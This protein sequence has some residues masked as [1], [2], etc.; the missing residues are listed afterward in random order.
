[1]RLEADSRSAEHRSAILCAVI[2]AMLWVGPYALR[3]DLFNNDAAHHIFWL[4]Q[5]ADASLFPNDLSIQYFRTSA[6]WGYRAL[7]SVVAP[8]MDVLQAAE[9]LSVGLLAVSMLLAWK[10]GQL[11]TDSERRLHGLLSVVALIVLIRWSGQRDLLPPIALQRAFALPLLLLTLWALM[12]RRDEWVGLSWIL[13]ALLYPV[14]LPV[15]GLTAAI[16]YLREIVR[17]RQMPDRW[18]LNALAGAVALALAATGMP[19]PPEVGPAFTYEQAMRMPEFGV[20]GRLAMYQQSF[21]GNWFTGHRTGLGWSPFVVLAIAAATFLA[22]IMGRIRRIPFAA[23]SMA[24]VGVGL[25]AAM[26]LFP[27][28]LMFG[29]YLP[30]RHSRWALGVFGIFALAVGVAAAIEYVARRHDFRRWVVMAS[31][32]VVTA[33][34]LPYAIALWN[35]PVNRDLENTYAFISTLPDST[36]VAAHPD[37]ANFVPLRSRRSVLTSTEIS[38]AWMSSYYAEMSPR[39]EASLRAA[40][41]TRIEEMDEALR[42][43]GSRRDVDGTVRLGEDRLFRALRSH[44]KG[45][46]S[47]EGN[48]LALR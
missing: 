31:P 45:T 20:A 28:Q 30:N 7:Y 22:L 9:L 6:P 26:R 3:T 8:I 2:A 16:V 4:Y 33:A 38:M 34:L 13:A 41:A 39:I 32:L 15:Q 37:L 40:Y 24:G 48:W 44:G 43:I 27:E 12:S 14:V 17:E 21:V 47:S 42:A 23:W 11:T 5:Y 10:I 36:L 25:W 18:R 1:M 19:I 46:A 29:L 35:R